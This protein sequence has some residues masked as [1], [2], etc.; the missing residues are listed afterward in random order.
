MNVAGKGSIVIILI[1]LVVIIIGLIVVFRK[2]QSPT[3]NAN[4]STTQDVIPGSDDEID[5]EGGTVLQE[6]EP[7]LGEDDSDVTGAGA[8]GSTENPDTPVSN[9]EEA[10]L[11]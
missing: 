1:V 5:V 4:A 11:Y 3:T 9:Q 10:P 7:V 2:L 8:E 6:D